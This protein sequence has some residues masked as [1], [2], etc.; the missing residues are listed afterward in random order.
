M[1][2]FS[3]VARLLVI[4]LCAGPASVLADDKAVLNIDFDDGGSR[5]DS[6]YAAAGQA[7]FWNLLD[8]LDETPVGGFIDGQGLSPP[9]LSE[10]TLSA[11]Q[12]MGT[13]SPHAQPFSHEDADLLGDYLVSGRNDAEI[14]LAGLP[15]GDYSLLLYF[16]GRQDY[17]RATDASLTVGSTAPQATTVSGTW[18]DEFAENISH[19]RFTFTVGAE[20]PVSISF[21][22][23][24]DAFI[25]GLQLSA[26]S[27]TADLSPYLDEA[28]WTWA[29][30]GSGWTWPAPGIDEAGGVG[31]EGLASYQRSS[32]TTTI[33]GP[34]HL[35]F[36]WR[37]YVPQ[38]CEVKLIVGGNDFAVVR[39][40]QGYDDFFQLY[41]P[42]AE[43]QIAW[44]VRNL[45]P[46]DATGENF[47]F[48]LDAVELVGD[49]TNQPPSLTAASLR[50][51]AGGA[52]NARLNI[53]DPDGDTPLIRVA[54]DYTGPE[55]Y[56]LSA[57][58]PGITFRD[59]LTGSGKLLGRSPRA[60][61]VGLYPLF[62]NLRDGGTEVDEESWFEITD[63]FP[64]G[65]RLHAERMSLAQV[66]GPEAEGAVLK[67]IES[68]VAW[69]Q[70]ST[71][72]GLLEYVYSDAGQW[73]LR[74]MLAATELDDGYT[75]GRMLA[76]DGNRLAVLSVHGLNGPMRV[77][78]YERADSANWAATGTFEIP[79]GFS[80]NQPSRLTMQGDWL[81]V[82]NPAYVQPED[83]SSGALFIY[84]YD[85]A[86]GWSLQ[87]Q[88]STPGISSFGNPLDLDNGTLVLGAEK[89][90]TTFPGGGAVYVFHLD[91]SRQWSATG[92]L[93]PSMSSQ[94][95][96]VFGR[97][98]ILEGGQLFVAN[99]LES[100]TGSVRVYNLRPDRLPVLHQ[101]LRED[102]AGWFGTGL[103][104][105]GH[106]L[107]VGDDYNDLNGPVTGVAYIYEKDALAYWR[108]IAVLS[109]STPQIYEGLGREVFASAGMFYAGSSGNGIYPFEIQTFDDW[110]Q[111]L[112]GE[113]SVPP[114]HALLGDE[115]RNGVADWID[116]LGMSRASG[117][118]GIQT[119]STEVGTRAYQGIR[120][121]TSPNAIGLPWEVEHSNDLLH[122]T[123]ADI[124]LI[125]SGDRQTWGI[126]AEEIG[127]RSF[128]RIRLLA[129]TE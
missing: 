120:F 127:E 44:E 108:R 105:Q 98:L 128:F 18:G 4:G 109:S 80:R 67:R 68:G 101:V 40:E 53:S 56:G 39:G 63:P 27:P 19:A 16:V 95:Y 114:P 97:D 25:N 82:T 34:T 90:A 31:I 115:N 24:G 1:H 75:F 12:G 3:V 60:I 59:D 62:V 46:S 92:K 71:E 84:D 125:E 122:W 32:L 72:D 70:T 102:S 52:S 118:A 126:P 35:R 10:L 58:P 5:P 113:P 85:A 117:R 73:E 86:S 8:G 93:V 123:S 43:N 6:S 51:V 65:M 89:D 48:Y 111:S 99:A 94:M 33:P 54:S 55:V 41:L 61:D 21:S 107:I 112:T 96:S 50:F 64:S 76:T 45:T 7:G 100:P 49:A 91:D 29:L 20:D 116:F 22:S 14:L 83:S 38:S 129:P 69:L 2:F 78:L 81:A 57:L 119:H 23:P 110:H 104:L 124:R 42:K 66:F 121:A 37:A 47:L 11:D 106:Q 9:W 103:A 28:G 15:E 17:S 74:S 88:F 79:G 77:H 87:Q 30:S 36:W 13:T 26:T